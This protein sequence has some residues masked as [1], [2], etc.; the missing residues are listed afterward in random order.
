MLD[1]LAKRSRANKPKS[2]FQGEIAETEIRGEKVLLLW[3]HTFMNLSGSS[4]LAARDFYKLADDELLVI[5][6]DFNLPLGKLRIRP[7]GSAGGQ[8]GLHD[9]IRR[10]G[11]EN[12][13]RL[14][15][16][17]G[18]VPAG[19]DGAA[20]VLGKF[21]KDETTEIEIAIQTAADAVEDW[22]SL[23]IKDCMNRYN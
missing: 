15:I 11:S 10:L 12:I 16:G 3:P 4:L 2:N 6:D 8:K 5:C 13:P 1:E 7:Q 23:G 18:P 9:V 22:I 14:R 17:V 21:T 19:W 20:F